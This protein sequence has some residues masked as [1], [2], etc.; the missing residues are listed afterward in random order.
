MEHLA[1]SSP[2]IEA[3]V[4]RYGYLYGP[5]TGADA[6]RGAPALH[7]DAAASAALLAIA[8]PPG[9]YNAAEP[10]AYLTTDK[11]RRAFAFD[12]NFRLGA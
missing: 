11:A 3:I 10:C 1:L 4:L 12:A 5:G 9:I 2:P 7:V 8:A 6:P